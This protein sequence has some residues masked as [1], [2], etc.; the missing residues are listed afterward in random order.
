[1]ANFGLFAFP[2]EEKMVKKFFAIILSVVTSGFVATASAEPV[3][4][5]MGG[6]MTGENS[7]AASAGYVGG[8][9]FN[10]T[11]DVLFHEVYNNVDHETGVSAWPNKPHTAFAITRRDTETPFYVMPETI[12]SSLGVT[13]Q[14]SGVFIPDGNIIPIKN[15]D[16]TVQFN[17]GDV[18][19]MYFFETYGNEMHS[20]NSYGFGNMDWLVN[21]I[22]DQSFTSVV[23]YAGE[24]V[25]EVSSSVVGAVI[26]DGN[27]TKVPEPASL[28]LL[29]IGLL[30]VGFIRRR[31]DGVNQ[32]NLPIAA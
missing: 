10:E 1:M 8:I 3:F 27:G 23:L 31:N 9:R 21:D 2:E 11:T 14:F 7:W 12:M 20:G 6:G 26:D 32:K 13:D 25:W 5:F 16:V 29:G 30:A 17:S 15:E 19:N 24:R 4:E 28:A 22:T 18:L